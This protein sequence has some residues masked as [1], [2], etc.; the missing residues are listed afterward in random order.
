MKRLI[1]LIPMLLIGA[2]AFAQGTDPVPPDDIIEWASRFPEMIGSFWGVV[3]SVTFLVPVLIGLFNQTEA[4]KIVKYLIMGF[5]TAALIA[6]ASLL[7][8]G[9]LNE[10]YLWFIILNAAAVIGAQIFGYALFKN[11]LDR[12]AEKFNPWKPSG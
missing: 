7:E 11:A 4:K 1:F 6:L 12:V 3:V 5:V 10:A 9:Y 8:M 2:M